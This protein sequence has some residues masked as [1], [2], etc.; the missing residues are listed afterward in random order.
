M[1]VELAGG[2][3]NVMIEL[4][5]AHALGRPVLAVQRT[6]EYDLRPR[7][8]EKLRMHTYETGEQLSGIIMQ[9]MEKF[10]LRAPYA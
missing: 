5:I 2:N 9:N 7:H 4:G 6:G 10:G 1:L 3:L 8:I